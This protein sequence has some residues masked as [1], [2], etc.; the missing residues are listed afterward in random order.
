LAAVGNSVIQK[1]R[2]MRRQHSL[3]TVW[4]GRASCAITR[5]LHIDV[6][7][8]GVA[9]VE[10]QSVRACFGGA[11]SIR[12][13]TITGHPCV[14]FSFWSSTL[15]AGPVSSDQLTTFFNTA[16]LEMVRVGS[17]SY[18]RYL[19]FFHLSLPR[20][21]SCISSTQPHTRMKNVS[22]TLAAAARRR[23]DLKRPLHTF[24]YLNRHLIDDVLDWCFTGVHN[25]VVYALCETLSRACSATIPPWSVA[26]TASDFIFF[27]RFR[28]KLV[29]SRGR[30]KGTAQA[31]DQDQALVSLPSLNSNRTAT[32]AVT[33]VTNHAEMVVSIDAF[34]VAQGA[35]QCQEAPC[36][37]PCCLF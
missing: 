1:M 25:H 8:C 19:P 30:R 20:L 31:Q 27:P 28:S 26:F 13:S 32:S 9:R 18:S 17:G 15:W 2:Q 23:A 35:R 5:G 33:D 12:P 24:S 22:R 16:Q 29:C 7:H 37:P 3:Q 21:F 4:D 34:F 14:H 6:I 36:L 10:P 11:T